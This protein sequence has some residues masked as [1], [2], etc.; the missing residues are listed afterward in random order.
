[1][2]AT[3]TARHQR[4]GVSNHKGGANGQAGNTKA[5]RA[6]GGPGSGRP[7]KQT[8]H[9]AKAPG[10]RGRKPK[11]ARDNGGAK[12][13]KDKKG[14]GESKTQRSGL[15]HPGPE[16]RESRRQQGHAE[17][18]T[19]KKKKKAKKGTRKGETRAQRKPSKREK[20]SGQRRAE[21]HQNALGRPARPTWLER[22]IIHT[23]ARDP[24][25]RPPTRRG[26]C[27]RQHKKAPVHRPSPPSSD[28]R[29]GKPDA[30]VTGSTHANHRSARSPRPTRGG[31]ARDN[32][33][34]G[35]LNG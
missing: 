28:G 3:K 4:G 8:T 10:I 17:K 2:A 23:H 9:S 7:T 12:K 18:M 1:M 24:A 21:A 31:P 27:R 20:Q 26:R 32:T 11:K 5:A 30:S 29:Y 34:A 25:W 13:N 6:H 16:T 19:T 33:I 35:S 15:R 22:T 14:A